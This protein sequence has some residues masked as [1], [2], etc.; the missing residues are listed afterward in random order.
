MS[1]I[2]LADGQR[3]R[4]ILGACAK[5]ASSKNQMPSTDFA[6]QPALAAAQRGQTMTLGLG[7]L[8]SSALFLCKC[9]WPQPCFHVN[10]AASERK[11]MNKVS[12]VKAELPLTKMSLGLSLLSFFF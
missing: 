8:W 10:I 12:A 1:C 5:P 7:S 11:L 2:Q 4:V 3:S 9:C 6:L